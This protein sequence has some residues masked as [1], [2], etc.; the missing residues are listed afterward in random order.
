MDFMKYNA[1]IYAQ[2][3]GGVVMALPKKIS[4]FHR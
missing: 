1:I 4:E 2:V 3:G